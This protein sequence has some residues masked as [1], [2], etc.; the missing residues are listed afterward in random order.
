MSFFGTKQAAKLL[1]VTPGKLQQDCWHGRLY[2]LPQKSPSGA[3]LW[4]Q[5]DLDR[6][7]W[8]ILHREYV[9]PKNPNQEVL[10]ERKQS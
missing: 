4:V 10:N 7:S 2:P 8:Q 6:Y 9:S 5:E 3:F 1:G